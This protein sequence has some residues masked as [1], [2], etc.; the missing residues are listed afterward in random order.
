MATLDLMSNRQQ[1][2]MPNGDIEVTYP[3]GVVKTVTKREVIEMA[4]KERFQLANMEAQKKLMAAE[5]GCNK[6]C[7]T[8]PPD[9]PCG[10][11]ARNKGSYEKGEMETF[12]TQPE[13]DAIMALKD[14]RKG[15]LTRDGC[16]IGNTL[17]REFM[18]WACL[19]LICKYDV[20]V[21][22]YD[23]YSGIT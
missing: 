19:E 14:D 4:R 17:G 15:W 13:R 8:P 22:K 23:I 12:F 2:L 3:T 7:G 11:C 10:Y 1:K 9:C 6:S 21:D 20:N 5:G 18:S 16:A